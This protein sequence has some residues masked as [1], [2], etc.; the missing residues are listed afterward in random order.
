MPIFTFGCSACGFE[1]EYIESFSVSNE[2]KHPKICPKCGKEK[3]QKIFDYSNSH[4]GFDIV[5]SCYTNDYGRKAWK[6]NLSREDQAKVLN[7]EKNPY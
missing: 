1:E 5:G 3:L 4:G 6:R 7:R 2:L